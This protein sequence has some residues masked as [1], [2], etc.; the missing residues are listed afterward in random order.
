MSRSYN[1]FQPPGAEDLSKINEL[2]QI[3]RTATALGEISDAF[4]DQVASEPAFTSAG[5]PVEN[6][7]L[8]LVVERVAG[9]ALE[10]A[11]RVALT[12]FIHIREHGF[13]HGCCL[14]G[15]KLCQVLYFEDIDRGLLTLAPGLLSEHTRFVRFSTVELEVD[16]LAVPRSIRGAPPA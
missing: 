11:P 1:P 2:R 14:L 7:C 6:P 13:W 4:W 15:G 10:R 5:R 3:L 12:M 8:R 9:Q 16:G